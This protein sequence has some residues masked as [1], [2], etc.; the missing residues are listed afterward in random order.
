M[1]SRRYGKVAVLMGGCSAEREV[2][3]N[4]GSAVLAALLSEGVE[5]YSVDTAQ[6][7]LS[8][9]QDYDRAF[10]VLHGRGGEDGTIQGALELMGVPYTG[11]GVLGSALGMDKVRSKLLWRGI[12]LP[13]PDFQLV[14]DDNVKDIPALLGFPFMIKPAE[15]GSSIGMAKVETMQEVVPAWECAR[16]FD[17]PVIA[18]AWVEGQEY[19]AAVLHKSVLP[20]IKL[21]TPRTFY[22]YDAKYRSDTTEYVCPCG[23]GEAQEQAFQQLC[24]RA[25]DQLGGGGWGRVDFMLDGDAQPWLLE[26]NTVPGMTDHSL[27][28]M[29]AKIAGKTFAQLVL[30]ILATSFR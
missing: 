24:M 11:S 16:Q 9:L 10:I 18:E 2:S 4:S 19:T 22:D 3:L 30:E 7:P 28:P 13:T 20:L 23:L 5:A 15:E 25:F 21:A 29:A 17:S 8:A 27:V 26:I 12:G 1:D 14:T 6:V